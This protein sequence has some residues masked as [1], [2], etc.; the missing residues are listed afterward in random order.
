[1][2]CLSEL[3]TR[4]LRISCLLKFKSDAVI[5]CKFPSGRKEY[6]ADKYIENNVVYFNT[7]KDKECSKT[8]EQLLDE[9]DDERKCEY[10]D[11]FKE[12]GL[13]NGENTFYDCL[14][15]VCRRDKDGDIDLDSRFKV[16]SIREEKNEI[17]LILKPEN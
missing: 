15:L 5:K 13:F 9:F 4:L 17:V 14:V 10:W 6:L 12:D 3:K 2:L 7:I 8:V 11:G 16:D 1:M